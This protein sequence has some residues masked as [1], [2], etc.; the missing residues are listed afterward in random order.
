[1]T[2]TQDKTSSHPTQWNTS[3]LIHTFRL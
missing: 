3:S 1:M 2:L